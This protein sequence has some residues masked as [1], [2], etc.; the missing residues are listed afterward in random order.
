MARLENLK[1]QIKKFQFFGLILFFIFKTWKIYFKKFECLPN[2]ITV[3]RQNHWHPHQHGRR[4]S[5]KA[6]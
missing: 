3:V 2:T 4:Q 1:P 6:T 5:D